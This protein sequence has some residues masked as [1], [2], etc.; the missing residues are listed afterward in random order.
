MVDYVPTPD[1]IVWCTKEVKRQHEPMEPYYRYMLNA[2]R[3]GWVLADSPEP[4]TEHDIHVL[5][6][7]VKG[8]VENDRFYARYRVTPVS[9]SSLS[10]GLDADQIPR[11][12]RLLIQY[13]DDMDANEFAKRFLD[14]HPFEDGNGRVASVLWNIKSGTIKRPKLMPDFYGVTNGLS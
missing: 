13:Q 7:M 8:I 2:W 3:H 12:M 1:V 4:I 9:F 6:G 11:Q 10:L 14:I 5:A